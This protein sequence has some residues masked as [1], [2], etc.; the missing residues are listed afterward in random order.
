MLSEKVYILF[1]IRSNEKPKIC[2]N[3]SKTVESNGNGMPSK[4]LDPKD[5]VLPKSASANGNGVLS[6]QNGVLRKEKL[7]SSGTLFKFSNSKNSELKKSTHRNENIDP[8]ANRADE[9]CK[10]NNSDHSQ[11]IRQIANGGK[12]ESRLCSRS[13][14]LSTHDSMKPEAIA[15]KI[16]STP[17]SVVNEA[18]AGKRKAENTSNSTANC[19]T[20][21]DKF[22]PG[23]LEKYKETYV[24]DDIKDI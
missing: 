9:S 23:G 3:N 4:L 22:L 19:A 16:S 2:K 24:F 7:S 1:F 5:K 15:D 21:T 14:S 18:P 20:S 17:S 6:A 12:E 8:N 11:G 13:N 10:G